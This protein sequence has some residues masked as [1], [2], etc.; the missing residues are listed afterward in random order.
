MLYHIYKISTVT[1]ENLLLLNNFPLLTLTT[2]HY[3]AEDNT[4]ALKETKNFHFS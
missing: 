2:M 4:P 3:N 1:I